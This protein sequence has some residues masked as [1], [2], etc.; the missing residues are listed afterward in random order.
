MIVDASAI[1]AILL[2]E[3]G[4]ERLARVLER[5]EA[6]ATHPISVYEAR[7][8]ILRELADTPQAAAEHVDDFLR[9][10][11][12]EVLPI[13]AE[14]ASLAF[15]AFSRYG[16]GRGARAALN[17]GDCFSYAVAK[18]SNRAILFVGDDFAHTDL[19]TPDL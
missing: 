15:A 2:E 6:A 12:I 9:R 14:T 5:A 10:A 7:G 16:R 3:P 1:V 18:V 4:F 19:A 11:T 8:A 13:T 17:M